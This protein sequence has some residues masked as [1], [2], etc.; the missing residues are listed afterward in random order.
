M[1]VT[2]SGMVGSGKTT[3][4]KK[5]LRWLCAQGHEPYYIRFRLIN[6]RSLWRTPAHAPWREKETAARTPKPQAHPHAV[7]PRPATSDKR[8][9]FAIFLGYLGRIVLFRL[10]VALHHRRHLLVVNRYFYDSFTHFRLVTVREQKLLHW[11]LKAAPQPELAI[12]L[13]LKPETSHRRRPAYALEELQ[14]LSENTLALKNYAPN[15][16]VVITDVISAVDRQVEKELRTI[17][18][19]SEKNSRNDSPLEGG[20]GGVAQSAMAI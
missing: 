12:L 15:L 20:Q 9:T 4:A 13:V 14:R 1:L 8:L 5:T 17:F 16:R 10:F 18:K 11:L 6:W 7:T 3:N 19:A 2:F